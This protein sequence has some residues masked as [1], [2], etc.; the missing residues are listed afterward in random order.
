MTDQ[1][2]STPMPQNTTNPP[3]PSTDSKGKDQDVD[4]KDTPPDPALMIA[5]VLDLLANKPQGTRRKPK[6]TDAELFYGERAKFTDFE[7]QVKLKLEADADLYTTD[8][9]KIH[10]VIQRLRGDPARWARP[11]YDE[12]YGQELKPLPTFKNFMDLLCRAYGDPDQ[13]GTAE[14]DLQKLRQRG[15]P[16]SMYWAEL[17][18]LAQIIGLNDEGK[19]VHFHNGV[20]SHIMEWLVT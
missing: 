11:Y 12:D 4:M 20:D 16:L 9:E 3:G 7:G 18:H 8:E 13:R 6:A 17:D 10:Y 14:R 19:K 15:R 2:Q 5:Q 1:G